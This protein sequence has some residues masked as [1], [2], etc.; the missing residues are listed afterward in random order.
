MHSRFLSTTLSIG[1][2]GLF[3]HRLDRPNS[4]ENGKP[5]Q[6]Q[7]LAT[8]HVNVVERRQSRGCIKTGFVTIGPFVYWMVVWRCGVSLGNDPFWL[9]ISSYPPGSLRGRRAT[10]YPLPG[11]FL[12]ILW[13]GGRQFATS[14]IPWDIVWLLDQLISFLYTLLYMQTARFHR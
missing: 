13:L 4:T 14:A 1:V 8:I 7:N 11:S 3:T 10:S 5:T 9:F 12:D 2:R 6:R